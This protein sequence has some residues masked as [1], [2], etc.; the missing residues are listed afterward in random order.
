[1][2][3]EMV[4]E[5]GESPEGAA[6]FPLIPPELGINPLLLGLLHAYVFLEGSEP[7]IIDPDA[8]SEAMEYLAGY[9][10]RMTG[11][12]LMRAREDLDTLAG[13]AKE[14]KWPRQQV[15]FLKSFLEENG[16]TGEAE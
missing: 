10:Q 13:Y 4:P 1:M 5:S 11:K 6:V 16:V 15:A 3:E 2:D 14:Q 12:D 9:L 7:N 8:A